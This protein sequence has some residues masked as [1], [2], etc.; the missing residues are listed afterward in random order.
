MTGIYSVKVRNMPV[1]GLQFLII[2]HP[3]LNLTV[4]ADLDL[5]KL[6]Q[7]FPGF[8]RFFIAFEH[9]AGIYV[10]LKKLH[11]N[12]YIHGGAFAQTP[13]GA[14]LHDIDILW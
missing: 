12:F 3:F 13:L 6:L 8:L 1:S 11:K 7:D 4:F 14:V 10:V 2:L 5:W 9:F